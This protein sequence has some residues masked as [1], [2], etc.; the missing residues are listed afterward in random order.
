[1]LGNLTHFSTS[2]VGV[3]TVS[4]NSILYNRPIESRRHR[5]IRGVSSVPLRRCGR[6]VYASDENLRYHQPHSQHHISNS[7]KLGANNFA[8]LFT[9]FICQLHK[10]I[11]KKILTAC[12]IRANTSLRKGNLDTCRLRSKSRITFQ[13]I[14]KCIRKISFQPETLLYN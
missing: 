6:K 8:T 7:F 11:F 9:R 4:Q 14:S 1:M 5:R 3:R 13:K 2:S 12:I 10:Y